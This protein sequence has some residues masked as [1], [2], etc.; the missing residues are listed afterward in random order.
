MRSVGMPEPSKPPIRVA[1]SQTRIRLR[2]ATARFCRASGAPSVGACGSA[3]PDRLRL[4]Q[5]FVQRDRQV[6]HAYAGRVVDR[7]GDRRG[8]A[9]NTYLADTLHAELIDLRV[10][11]VDE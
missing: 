11:L 5:H 10:R 2:P 7:V 4:S 8:H 9:D 6:A 1:P 3:P